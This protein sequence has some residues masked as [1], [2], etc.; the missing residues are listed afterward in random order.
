MMKISTEN[1]AG[2]RA[3]DW[4]ARIRAT[5]LPTEDPQDPQDPQ[6]PPPPLP[7]DEPPPIPEGDPP[8]EA[9]PERAA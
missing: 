2:C 6:K 8:S 4:P 7:G 1:D 5:H 9:P 3:S